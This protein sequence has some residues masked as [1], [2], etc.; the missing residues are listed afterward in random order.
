MT[1]RGGEVIVGGPMM[2]IA[3]YDT[4]FPVTKSANCILVK[5]ATPVNEQNCINCGRCVEV[6]PMGLMPTLFGKYAKKGR[7]DDAK[8]AY[9]ENSIECGACAYVCP[10]NIPLVQY[11][12]VAKREIARRAAK[13]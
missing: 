6:C 13:K 2:G 1:E 11:I 12:K 7:W 8:A 10:A 4:S 9:V 3:I 5:E